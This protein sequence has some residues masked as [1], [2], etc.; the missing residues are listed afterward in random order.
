[1]NEAIKDQQKQ[2]VSSEKQIESN[3]AEM[4]PK[5]PVVPGG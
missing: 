2:V 5:A 3:A 1:M 4:E